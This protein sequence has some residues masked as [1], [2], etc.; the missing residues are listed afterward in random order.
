MHEYRCEYEDTEGMTRSVGTE[1]TSGVSAAMLVC[2]V[3][4]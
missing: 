4:C 2:N 1:P 3:A